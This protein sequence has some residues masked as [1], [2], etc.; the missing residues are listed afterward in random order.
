MKV[1]LKKH[2]QEGHFPKMKFFV[3]LGAPGSGKGTQAQNLASSNA[4]RLLHISTGQLIRDEI[5]CGTDLGRQL[6][7]KTNTGGL[8]SDIDIFNVLAK[9]LAAVSDKEIVIL[10]GFPRTLNQAEL[11]KEFAEKTGNT[12]ENVVYFSI[13]DA[14]LVD[15]L[16]GRF[17]CGHCG[18]VY[19]NHHNAPKVSGVC[20]FCGSHDFHIRPDDTKEVVEKRLSVFHA[21]TEPLVS[22]YEA[23]GVL[24]KLDASQSVESIKETLLKNISL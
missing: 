17:T 18:A 15:R 1:S 19:H 9:K 14:A 6:K 5:N 8:V 11:L 23:L 21:E 10:D 2:V 22:Y 7:E 13:A 16:A 12:I 4:N 24:F 20:D 3:F